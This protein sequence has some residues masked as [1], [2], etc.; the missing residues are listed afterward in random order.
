MKYFKASASGGT[1]CGIPLFQ[2]RLRNYKVVRLGREERVVLKSN[3]ENLFSAFLRL[4]ISCIL[5]ITCADTSETVQFFLNTTTT[6]RKETTL[7][8][9]PPNLH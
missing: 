7:F 8:L 1:S 6:E 4:M 9:F 2:D 3:A 5:T